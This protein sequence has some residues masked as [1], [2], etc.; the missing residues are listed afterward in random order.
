MLRIITGKAGTGKSRALMS[1]IAERVARHEGL[2]VLIVPEQYSHEAERELCAVCGDELSMYAEV[3]SFTG[4]CRSIGSEVGGV[5]ERYLDKGGRL[6]CMALAADGLS[7]KL[8][9][10]SGARRKAELQTM[11]LSAVDELKTA[12]VTPEMLMAASLNSEGALSDKLYDLSLVLEAYDAVVANGHADPTDRLTLLAR[13]IEQSP[14]AGKMNIYID[15]FTDFTAQ[16]REV[17]K[18][19]LIKGAYVTVCLSCDDIEGGSEVFELSRI[20]VRMLTEFAKERGIECKCECYD[21]SSTKAPALAFFADRLFSYTSEQTDSNGTL[22]V[23]AARDMESECELAAAESV[24][25]VRETGCRRRDI[26]VA[27]RGFEDYRLT[28]EA[29]FSHYGVPLYTA[30][31]SD[32]FSKPLPALIASAY[33]IIGGGWE[34]DDICDYLRTGL[35]GLSEDECDELES[36]AYMWQ[37]HGSAWTRDC[38][39]RLHP[40]GYGKDIDEAALEE[41][42]HINAL[43]RRIVFPLAHFAQAADS[44]DTAMGQAAALADFLNELRLAELLKDKAQKLISDGRGVTAQEYSQLWELCVSALEQCAAILGDAES[45]TES[46]GRLFTSV[47]S[48][49]D[50]GTIPATLDSVTAGDFDRMRRRNIK[51]LIVLGA[52]D[53]RLPRQQEDAGVFS[54]DERRRLIEMDIDLGGVGDSELWREFSIIYNCLTLPSDTL[55]LCYPLFDKK[56]EQCRPSFVVRRALAMTGEKPITAD[57]RQLRMNAAAPALG[58]AAVSLRKGGVEEA[59]AG[60]LFCELDPQRMDKLRR[61]SEQSRGSLSERSVMVLYG[62]KPTLSAS[63]IDKFASCR[64]AYFMQYGL[65]AKPLTTAG[66]TPPELGTFMHGILEKVARAADEKGGFK[67]IT[68]DELDRITDCLV[69][70]YV[71]EKLNDFKEKT[72]RFEYLFRRLTNEVRQ[73]VRDMANELRRSDFLPL[74]FELDFSKTPEL[75]PIELGDDGET[76]R[77]TGVADRVDGWVHDDKLYLRVM[78]Y[79]TGHKEFSLADVWYGMGLQMLLYLF[80]L[81]ANGQELYGKEIVPAGVLYIPAMSKTVTANSNLDDEALS[82]ESIRLKCR[83]GLILDD[84]EVIEAMEHGDKPQ[85]IPVT[86]KNGVPTGS[87]LASAE[88]LG[89]LSRHVEK[90]LC[91]MSA[92]LKRGSIAA[93]PYYRSQQDNACTY[94]DY[95]DACHFVDG[96]NGESSRRLTLSATKIWNVLEGGEQDG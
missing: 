24:R 30:R 87:S 77:L 84:P 18:A 85:Y 81:G 53:T 16:E 82:K 56:G 45:D 32:L 65:K 72:K 1:E 46:F 15:G 11:L 90:T 9:V 93:D 62:K 58:L 71:H 31:K 69:E 13:Q 59:S 6:L 2:N 22:R 63:R 67:Y 10:Y 80:S 38:D 75:P 57:L 20:T 5:S 73:V 29:A 37:L 68:D 51:H 21:G 44:A 60:A 43:R 27:V 7:S 91:E 33:E 79:K 8:R 55:T 47:L 50:V 76:L 17:I 49:Y 41:L 23:I 88:R 83:S 39:W 4:L 61:A 28:L 94:C 48:R 12:C 52:S 92:A 14:T 95:F 70:E 96:E 86:F 78:D 89:L 74:S 40:Q 34:L 19:L 54:A 64:F 42:A 26:A 3:L 35:T 66:L 25:L 36:Y